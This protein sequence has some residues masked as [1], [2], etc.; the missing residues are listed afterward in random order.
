MLWSGAA[1]VFLQR[2]QRVQQGKA[3]GKRGVFGA[4]Q[5]AG[6]IERRGQAAGADAE[7]AAVFDGKAQAVVQIPLHRQVQKS[8]V[9][10]HA[11]RFEQPEHAVVGAD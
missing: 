2:G 5:G 7:Q 9:A 6:E 11:G 1:G 8:V 10:A 4:E 3:Q